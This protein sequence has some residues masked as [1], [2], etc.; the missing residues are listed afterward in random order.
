MRENIHPLGNLKI[1]FIKSCSKL[2]S[3]IFLLIL[4]L[5]FRINRNNS[6]VI[7]SSAFFAPWKEDK[8]FK[9]FY[10]KILNTTILDTK[11]LYTLWFFS[12]SLQNVNADIVDLG[13]LKGGAGFVMSKA[14]V[15]G[16]VYLIDTFEGLIEND[17]H[18]SKNHFVFKNI[19]SVKTK[20]KNL[21]LKK[22]SVY[23]LKFPQGAEK[24]I[25]KSKIKLCHLDVNT[26]SSTKKSFYFI[27]KRL[28]K[29]GVIVFDDYGIHSA[30]GIKKFVDQLI[31]KDKDFTFVN[32]Y[33]GQCILIK[34]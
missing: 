4:S 20:V 12:K 11:R 24:I 8:K 15:K 21:K 33:M 30:I 7:I 6:E 17:H 2:V 16:K 22:T 28:I 27:K 31:K 13:C 19:E 1:K 32:N 23:K 9:D 18:H 14:N 29:N 10:P 5:F 3:N 34:K 26:F 25:K